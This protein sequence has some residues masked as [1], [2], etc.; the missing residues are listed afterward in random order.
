M[1]ACLDIANLSA[2]LPNGQRVLRS[3]SLAVQPGEV[4]AL[5]GESGAGKTM[6]GKAVLGV[7]PSSVRIV[8]GDIRFE[9]EDLGRLRP[10]ARRTLIGARTALIPQDPLTAL[11]PSRRIGPQMTDR[12]VRI[13]GWGGERADTR[14]RQL[15]DE[16]QIRDPERVLKSYPHELSG[17]MRQRVL[18]AAAFAAEPRL[19][20]ADEPT[21]ALDVTVQKQILRLIA[22]LQRE[23]G[24]AI[25]FVTHDLG[26]VAKI[27]QKVSVLYAGKV[28]EETDTADLFAAPRHLYTRA[29]M[30]ATPRYTDPL[31]SLKPVDET[32]LAGLAAE[33]AAADQTWRRPNG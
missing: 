8:E 13:L 1:S 14:I 15:L 30:A 12:L 5:V 16:V 21:T 26:V 24:T 25:L 17:G 7:L 11:N 22:Q 10:K 32:V 23:H 27:S 9:G 3:V 4:R 29:L 18:I 19:I 31:A 28:V 6:I 20:V 33:I 2:V